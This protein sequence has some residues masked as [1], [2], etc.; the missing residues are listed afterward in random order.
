MEQH[1]HTSCRA[2]DRTLDQNLFN[3][4]MAGDQSFDFTKNDG[5]TLYIFWL[6]KEHKLSVSEALKEAEDRHFKR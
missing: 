2:Y 6:V 3:S 1:E 4:L 5:F